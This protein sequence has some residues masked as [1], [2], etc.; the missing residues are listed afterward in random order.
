[1]SSRIKILGKYTISKSKKKCPTVCEP[2]VSNTG[3]GSWDGDT[4]EPLEGEGD[5]GSVEKPGSDSSEGSNNG[6]KI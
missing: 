1:M 6:W 3:D 2:I 5:T 4:N